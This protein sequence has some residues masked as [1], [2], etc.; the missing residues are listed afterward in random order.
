MTQLYYFRQ[1]H[2]YQGQ[3]LLFEKSRHKALL[4][5]YSEFLKNVYPYTCTESTE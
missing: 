1:I 2:K 3:A 4:T 5:V